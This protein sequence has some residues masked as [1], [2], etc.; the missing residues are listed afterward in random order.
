VAE[1]DLALLCTSATFREGLLSVLEAGLERF[2]PDN[3]PANLAPVLVFRLSFSEDDFGTAHVVRITVR[4][5]DGEPVAEV[6]V[7]VTYEP[8]AE[9]DPALSHFTVVIHQLLMQIRRDGLYLVE[10]T[11]DGELSS[12]IPFRVRARLPQ[13]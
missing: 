2:S 9:S 6:G 3:Y 10:I 8:P 1:L 5:D 13:A 11:L 12:R 4:H 7:G